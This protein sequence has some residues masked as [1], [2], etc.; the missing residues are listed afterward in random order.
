MA[1]GAAFGLLRDLMDRVFRTTE[2][3]KSALQTNCLA[4]VPMVDYK[5]S[6][7]KTIARRQL[8]GTET[9]VM[10]TI[11]RGSNTL[12]TGSGMP[13]SHFAE[14]IRFIKLAINLSST[15][16]QNKIIGITSALPNEGKSTIAAAVG[17]CIAQSGARVI[18][19]DCDLRNPSL[20]AI[21]APKADAGLLEVLSGQRSPEEA[22]WRDEKT[23]LEFLPAVCK[24]Q[25]AHSS[26]ILSSEA[27]RNLFEALRAS[28]DYVIVDLPPLTPIVDV[29][30]TAPW[31]DGYILTIEWGRTNIDVVQHALN[32]APDVRQSLIG[33]ILNKADMNAIGR[34]DRSE[35]PY[36]GYKNNALE[37]A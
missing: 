14:S 7:Q 29:R 36:P 28:Y 26:D 20:S 27:T 25:F 4:L 2:Q 33:A 9:R 13:L 17:E 15:G 21:L 35:R 22:I 11:V 30:A 34:Y 10:R 3:V 8:P 6:P 16:A 37:A 19:V 5:N 18:V 24:S 23:N 31:I 1:L 12:W 32:T